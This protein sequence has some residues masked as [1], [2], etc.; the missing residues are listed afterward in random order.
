MVDFYDFSS[1]YPQI[2]GE[3]NVDI[4]AELENLTASLTLADDE[5]SLVLPNGSVVGHR[6][7]KRYY[8]QKL[9]PEEVSFL[10]YNIF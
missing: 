6:A 8:D 4:D 10:V 1:S 9:K 3:E 7:M 2:E 5:M